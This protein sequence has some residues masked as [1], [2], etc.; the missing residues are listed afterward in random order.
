MNN[1]KYFLCLNYIIEIC[2]QLIESR[3]NFEYKFNIMYFQIA[4]QLF[5]QIYYI[6]FD[7]QKVYDTSLKTSAIV[8]VLFMIQDK[9]EKS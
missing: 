1:P 6:Y 4:K 8:I 7:I 2:Q 5:F 9:E 3:I